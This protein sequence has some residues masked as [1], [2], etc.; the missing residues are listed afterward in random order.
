AGFDPQYGAR[1]LRRAIQQQLQNPLAKL[2]I[3]GELTDGSTVTVDR[4]ED[5][6][7]GDPLS[8]AVTAPAP[9]PT[10]A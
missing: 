2:L 3:A 9:A 7:D 5:A 8:F 6:A 1:P 4:A 10:A